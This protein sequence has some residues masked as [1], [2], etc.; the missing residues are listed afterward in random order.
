MRALESFV[1][2]ASPT[3]DRGDV[4]SSLCTSS[5]QARPTTSAVLTVPLVK[6]VDYPTHQWR[7]F[8]VDTGRRFWRVTIPIISLFFL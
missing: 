8:M 3:S 4:D 6:I 5:K 7:G 2:L 1:Q